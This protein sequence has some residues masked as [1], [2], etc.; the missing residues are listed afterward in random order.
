MAMIELTHHIRI[1][2]RLVDRFDTTVTPAKMT[3]RVLEVQDGEWKITVPIG[4]VKAVYER[5]EKVV[6]KKK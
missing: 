4:G 1:A 6:E 2:G 3:D 5:A